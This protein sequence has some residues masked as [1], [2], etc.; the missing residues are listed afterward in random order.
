MMLKRSLV[1]LFLVMI[2]IVF[3]ACSVDEAETPQAQM[4]NPV[5]ESSADEI[6]EELGF[7]LLT[8]YG[9]EDIAYSIIDMSDEGK[10]A[11]VDFTLDGIGYTY[12]AMAAAEWTDISGMY[13]E[14]TEEV[15]TDVSYNSGKTFIAE[16]GDTK[17]GV[18]LWYDT[19]PGI[20]YSLSMDSDADYTVLWFMAEQLFQPGE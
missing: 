15:E 17:V 16:D 3:V 2:S 1:V 7:S 18:I 6:M 4:P 11:Q 9:A 5:Q 19:V 12:R 20:Q 14:W 13:F 8:P 10:M